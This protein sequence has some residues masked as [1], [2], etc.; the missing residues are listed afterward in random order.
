MSHAIDTNAPTTPPGPQKQKL[1][2]RLADQDNVA[3]PVLKQ[4]RVAQL[5]LQQHHEVS[6]DGGPPKAQATHQPHPKRCLEVADSTEDGD[7]DDSPVKVLSTQCHPSKQSKSDSSS[8]DLDFLEEF[9]PKKKGK[10][11]E[12]ATG[13]TE[14]PE[15]E[16]SACLVCVLLQIS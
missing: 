6:D 8:N 16:L 5:A 12:A 1:A 11:N 10:K 4:Q 3:H 13:V 15:Q 7:A 9:V 2:A 14:T